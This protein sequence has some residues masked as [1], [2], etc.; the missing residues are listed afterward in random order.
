MIKVPTKTRVCSKSEDSSGAVLLTLN[1][2]RN[3]MQVY[4]KIKHQSNAASIM[5]VSTAST[6]IHYMVE[7]QSHMAC[8]AHR[9]LRQP[10]VGPMG[11]GHGRSHAARAQVY[12]RMSVHVIA[13]G[14]PPG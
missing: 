12:R 10:V 1:D 11:V 5:M 2:Q 4:D 3:F 9:V 7:I 13:L 6:N 8:A 14:C